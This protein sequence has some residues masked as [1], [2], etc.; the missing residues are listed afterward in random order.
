MQSQ[1][2]TVPLNTTTSQAETQ[3]SQCRICFESQ[4]KDLL[5]SPCRCSGS[6]KFVHEECL[7]LWILS[8]NPEPKSSSCELCKQAFIIEFEL[9]RKCSFTNFTNECFNIFIFPLVIL[10]I[11][12]VFAI[13]LYYLV[14]GIKQR[15]L[16]NE[17]KVYFSLIV[18]AC[19][20]IITALMCFL[21]K[22]VGKACCVMKMEKWSVKSLNFKELDETFEVCQTE[23]NN[24]TNQVDL[25]ADGPELRMDRRAE[26]SLDARQ[27][28]LDSVGL[29]SG[30]PG[31]RRDGREV[32]FRSGRY[33]ERRFDTAVRP[34]SVGRGD[35]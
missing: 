28:R 13:A 16:G 14:Q 29:G 27:A 18:F 3:L 15:T 5:I 6:M 11:S 34:F 2:K 25:N 22:T 12:I 23:G 10:I 31:G 19:F 17:E 4:D 21:V 30:G 33:V 8:S 26:D 35:E 7:K 24:C 20:A 32:G 9:S 1:I